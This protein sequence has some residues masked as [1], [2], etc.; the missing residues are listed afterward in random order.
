MAVSAADSLARDLRRIV[1][2]DGVLTGAA[3][4][5]YV[6][7]A[8]VPRGVK[9]WADA[10]ALPRDAAEVAA[11]VDYCYRERLVIIPRGGGTGFAGGAVADGGVLLGLER[12]DRVLELE[13]T[14]WRMT[15]QAGVTTRRVQQLARQS[16]LRFP[17]D[18]GAPEQSQ[19]G[20][21]VATNAGGP[22]AFKYGVTGAFVMGLEAVVPPGEPIRLGGKT[23]KDVAGYD[24]L[25]L[26][27]GSE[28]TLGV[29]TETTLRLIPA[30]E[31]AYP[32]VAVLE[33]GEAAALGLEAAFAS[34][35]VPAAVEYFDDRSWAIARRAF[36]AELPPGFV[37]ICEADG[38]A[39]EA[40]QGR[41]LL[42]EALGEHALH[43][44]A[45][46]D[47]A[48][49]AELWRWREG[50]SF[51]VDAYHGGKLSEDIAVPLER[52]FD[53]VARTGEIAERHGLDWCS[54]GHGGDGNLHSC[55]L[56]DRTDEDA[57]LR[58]EAAAGE[59]LLLAIELG[60]TISG[61]HG[62]GTLKSGRLRHQWSP[63]AVR[64]HEAVKRTF[65]PEG[66]MNP[67]KKLA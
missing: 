4:E 49:I 62:L 20:G 41:E 63:A 3:L 35:T 12:L 5:P 10:L 57:R 47:R 29:V 17:P 23:R 13:P 65:D 59:L 34:G 24:L 7:D 6:V 11:V 1:G 55:F 14:R 9:G 60:G 18:P 43:V 42:R 16:G 39:E 46:T 31:A 36:P 8:T 32:V 25:H 54:F 45:P 44:Y 58:A 56:F 53:G 27:V 51:L 61:E 26:L 15:V 21:N 50:V 40:A 52:L 37:L 22:H 33:D 2:Q 67:G 64:L 30:A 38:S 48:E 19:I 66:L 28:G